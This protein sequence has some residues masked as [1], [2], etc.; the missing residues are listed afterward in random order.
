MGKSFSSKKTKKNWQ[1]K[2]YTAELEI[3]AALFFWDQ[4]HRSNITTPLSMWP[5]DGSYENYVELFFTHGIGWSKSNQEGVSLHIHSDNEEHLNSFKILTR[6]DTNALHNLQ[7]WRRLWGVLDTWASE[8]S[9]KW[10]MFHVEHMRHHATQTEEISKKMSS[11]IEIT[12]AQI[13]EMQAK[14]FPHQPQF[15]KQAITVSLIA[16]MRKCHQMAILNDSPLPQETIEPELDKSIRLGA[17]LYINK[18]YTESKKIGKFLDPYHA[19]LYAIQKSISFYDKNGKPAI[20]PKIEFPIYDKNFKA[21]EST[22][23]NTLSRQ[24]NFSNGSAEHFL[25]NNL[26]RNK[27]FCYV[28]IP[29]SLSKESFETIYEIIWKTN[30]LFLIS[31]KEDYADGINHLGTSKRFTNHNG[32]AMICLSNYSDKSRVQPENDSSVEL[33]DQSLQPTFDF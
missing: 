21:I 26:S 22:L 14:E 23:I 19:M 9:T 12:C 30:A 5:S 7:Q 11:F 2:P 16:T 8:Y 27:V 25:R 33:T 10:H 31:C 6:G 4:P 1:K 3:P 18:L 13:F 15:F 32:D 29:N 20:L 24:T 28:E 17:L